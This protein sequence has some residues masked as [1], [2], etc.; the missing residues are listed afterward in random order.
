M[1]VKRHFL[2]F[3]AVANTAIGSLVQRGCKANMMPRLFCHCG[4]QRPIDSAN[5]TASQV[6]SLWNEGMVKRG[7][8]CMHP[9]KTLLLKLI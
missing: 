6:T 3:G 2:Q 1:Y 5:E 8:M 7:R 9:K 4:A